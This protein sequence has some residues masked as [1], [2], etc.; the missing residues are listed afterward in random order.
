MASMESSPVGQLAASW[1]VGL[2]VTEMEL[3]RWQDWSEGIRTGR[4]VVLAL[5]VE[6]LTG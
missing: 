2:G 6:A 5:A 3:G 4:T 1:G